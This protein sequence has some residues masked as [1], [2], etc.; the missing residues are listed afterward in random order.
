LDVKD[1]VLDALVVRQTVI[2]DDCTLKLLDAPDS[3]IIERYLHYKL[4]T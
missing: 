3:M 4:P 2:W 1:I